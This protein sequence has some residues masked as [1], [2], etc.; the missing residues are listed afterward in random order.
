[1]GD[2]N[3]SIC[4]SLDRARGHHRPLHRFRVAFS[5]RS[6]AR[7]LRGCTRS[8]AQLPALRSIS[9]NVRL[10]GFGYDRAYYNAQGGSNVDGIDWSLLTLEAGQS[11]YTGLDGV[12]WPDQNG[13]FMEGYV[14]GAVRAREAL[15]MRGS[16]PPLFC[17]LSCVVLALASPS[18][19]K[20]VT[21][22]GGV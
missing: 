3:A 12:Y 9:V 19:C 2:A 13:I 10:G 1:M 5:S 18:H 8:G 21:S 20:R 15:P 16:P 22:Q 4:L 11:L 14:V 17:R 7:S 6:R